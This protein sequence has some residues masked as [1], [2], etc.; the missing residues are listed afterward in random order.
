[1]I[2]LI[3]LL[4]YSTVRTDCTSRGYSSIEIFAGS[5]SVYRGNSETLLPSA[6]NCVQGTLNVPD[7]K[8]GL[9][10]AVLEAFNW[11]LGSTQQ[12]NVDRELGPRFGWRYQWIIK[13]VIVILEC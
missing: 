4:T 6:E 9:Q 8:E 3:W 5:S 1:M 7:L 11:T 12:L 2:S 10:I 13:Y